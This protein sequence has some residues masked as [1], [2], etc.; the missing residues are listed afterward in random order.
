VSTK[1]RCHR[2]QIC[3]SVIAI[4]LSWFLACQKIQTLNQPKHYL[5]YTWIQPGGKQRH[6]AKL[7][8]LFVLH[9][10]LKYK[11]IHKHETHGNDRQLTNALLRVPTKPAAKLHNTELGSQP[12]PCI[13]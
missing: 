9:T 8:K 2:A 6:K 12:T 7:H 4:R 1:S 13:S 3:A 11:L 10:S 5:L